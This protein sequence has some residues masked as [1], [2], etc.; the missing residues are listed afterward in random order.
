MSSFLDSLERELVAA[1]QRHCV[2]A[3]PQCATPPQRATPPRPATPP[4][5]RLHLRLILAAALIALAL[6]AAALAATGVL[7]TG[8]AVPPIPQSGPHAGLGIPSRGGSRLIAHSVSDPA[9]GAR[10]SMRIVHTSRDLICL[11][12][13]RLHRG[14]IGV[15]G[16]D[17]AFHDDG[18]F[19]PLP[20]ELIA[21]MPRRFATF[22]E[23]EGVTSEV[24]VNAMPASA[25]MPAEGA[26]GKP[27]QER[28]LYFG[29][30][31]PSAISL[32]YRTSHGKRTIPVEP[33][34]GAYLIVLRAHTASKVETY[35]GSNGTFAVDEGR[36]RAESPI[37]EITYDVHGHPCEEGHIKPTGPHP[38]PRESA[39]ELRRRMREAESPPDLNLPIHI[40]LQAQSRNALAPERAKPGHPAPP[41]P[42]QVG[43]VYYAAHIS[44]RAPF[45]VRGAQSSYSIL[46]TKL[47]GGAGGVSSG[48]ER[49]VRRGS[50]VHAIAPDVFANAHGRPVVVKILYYS[51]QA[52]G[53]RDVIVGQATVKEP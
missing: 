18:L 47:G 7:F 16:E 19:H 1:A 52:R 33:G 45:A 8:S 40:S 30:L 46:L 34:T 50:T 5:R 10:W 22:C 17:G 38:C 43:G 48:I 21:M 39:A 4:R 13:G 20:R 11:Q 42:G 37:T 2:E 44:F 24:D 31:G 49:D 3:P 41:P 9:G 36:I 12:V 6:A 25:E 23:P 26:L 14:E 29:L 28:R 51:L 32:T 53:H 15:I 27:A 35:G